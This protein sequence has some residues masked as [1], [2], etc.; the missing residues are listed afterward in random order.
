V[1]GREAVHLRVEF[2]PGTAKEDHWD[3]Y[4]D[5][6]TGIVLGLVIT[7]L[8]G[9]PGYEEWIDSVSINPSTDDSVC[10]RSSQF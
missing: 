10:A 3:V 2:P 9:N 8:P 5:A 7:P 1:A 4:V 6:Q